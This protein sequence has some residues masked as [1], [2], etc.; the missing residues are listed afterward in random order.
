MMN[1]FAVVRFRY[2]DLERCTS[3][4]VPL[5]DDSASISR[6]T[7]PHTAR[8]RMLTGELDAANAAFEVGYESPSQFNREYRRFLASRRCAISRHCQTAESW[9]SLPLNAELRGCSTVGLF[10]TVANRP[11]RVSSPAILE[12]CIGDLSF[13]QNR[14][15]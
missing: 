7:S 6:A 8:L 15:S 5:R 1:S 11:I 4:F 13:I 10:S 3:I 14:Y 12:K 9:R 2:A